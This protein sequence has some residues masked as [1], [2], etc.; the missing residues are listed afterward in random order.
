M[1]AAPEDSS[2]TID[3]R[4]DNAKAEIERWRNYHYVIVN[5]D[6]QRAYSDA[7]AIVTAER[8]RALR[9]A[10]GIESFVQSLIHG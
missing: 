5:D 10:A 8:L 2:Q 9:A 3:Q 4:L 7:L 1:S 6:L